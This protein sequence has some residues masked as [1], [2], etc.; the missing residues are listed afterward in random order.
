MAPED[1]EWMASFTVSFSV[2]LGRTNIIII[3]I[4][5]YDVLLFTIVCTAYYVKSVFV[6]KAARN[7]RV[8]SRFVSIELPFMIV[9]PSLII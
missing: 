5:V 1:V 2:L 8:D 6:V 9:I 4:D 7:T 3:S